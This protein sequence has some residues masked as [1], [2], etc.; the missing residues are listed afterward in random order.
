VKI[1]NNDIHHQDRMITNTVGGNDDTGAAGVGFV[2]TTGAILAKGNRLWANR[3]PSHDYG[4]DG[5]AFEIYAASNVTMTENVMWDNEGVLESG[6]DSGVACANNVFTR[7]T[8]YDNN[9]DEINQGLYL[10]CASNM[11]IANNT[12]HNLDWWVYAIDLG[13]TTYSGAI[14]G[15]KIVN[16]IHQMN[17]SKIYGFGANIPLSTMTID[18]NLDYNPGN[19]IATMYGKTG[20]STTAAMAT[21]T[22]KQTH[23]VN[24]APGFV[25]AGSRDYRLTSSSA[26][27]NEGT[28][29]SPV[30]NGYNGT[31]PDMG[32]HEYGD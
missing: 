27:I 17:S 24:A 6:T 5:G 20:M 11:L 13:S 4:R 10:R 18:Y 22:G 32:R 1:L 23:G 30:T 19:L 9:P 3:A 2:H 26:A 16:N 14:D 7:N 31:A 29:W 15:I 28:V 21:T 25:N 12:F 8:A